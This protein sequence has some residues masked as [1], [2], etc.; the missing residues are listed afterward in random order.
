M[1]PERYYKIRAVL[2]KR[3][4]DLGVLMENVNK[5]HNLAAIIR[6]CDA[7][8]VLDAHAVSH[9]E[10]IRMRQKAASGSSKWVR[11]NL[12][13]NLQSAITGLK[14]SGH[15]VIAVHVDPDAIDYRQVDYCKPT[16]LLMGEELEGLTTAAIGQAD[17]CVKIPMQGM[18]QSLNV[19]VAT[20]LIL[21]QAMTQR[22]SAG[23]YDTCR[24]QEKAYQTL[25]FEWAYPRMAR[26]LKQKGEP[27][28]LV[29]VPDANS[30]AV[31]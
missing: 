16:V 27:Y 13:A 24:L 22:Q 2:D 4:P 23:L 11:L 21:Y 9:Y 25:L 29:E 28:P 8:G 15:Q 17:A 31:T 20:A 30:C 6:S 7:V 3:Q 12:H 5:A 14:S 19:S 10:S 18:V 26:L 1:T